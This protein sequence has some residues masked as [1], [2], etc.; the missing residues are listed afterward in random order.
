M[1]KQFVSTLTEIA[2]ADDRVVL[3]TADLGFMVLEPFAQRHPTRFFN[4]GVAEANMLS[5]AAGMASEELIPFCYS[6]ATFASMRG[7][8]QFRNGAVLH[9]LPVRIVGIGG[10]FAYGSAGFTHHALE[11]I[12]LMRVQP[13]VGIIAPADDAQVDRALRDHYSRPQP[14]YLRLAKETA[15]HPELQGRFRWSRLEVIGDGDVVIIAIGSMTGVALAVQ[16]RLQAE[17]T[18]V[19]VAV[20]ASVAPAPTDDLVA[21]L[22]SAR[23]CITIEDHRPVGGVGSLVAETIAEHGLSTRLIR[24]GIS[25]QPGETSGSEEFLRRRNGLDVDALMAL[26]RQT[27]LIPA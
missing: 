16:R 14:M 27:A 17:G 15:V 26:V 24:R 11:D 6:I 21:L 20:V 7:Y 3:L 1:R 25:D 12:A 10:G 18:H 8:E 4:V 19:A 9:H 2:D 23:A 13:N 22:A 5:L